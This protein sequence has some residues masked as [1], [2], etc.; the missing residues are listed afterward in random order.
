M[1]STA[2]IP[3]ITY[4][5]AEQT[6][7]VKRT[8]LKDR[9]ILLDIVPEYRAQVAY[10][11]RAQVEDLGNMELLEQARN[12]K[13]EQKE[14]SKPVLEQIV[15]GKNEFAI[16]I[17]KLAALERAVTEQQPPA[18]SPVIES[19]PSPSHSFMDSIES[20]VKLAE[21]QWI[22]TRKELRSLGVPNSSIVPGVTYRGFSFERSGNVGRSFG[23]RVLL[24]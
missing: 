20:L 9:M 5:E 7:G 21:N 6:L 3:E 23:W 12:T 14:I 11:T 1:L 18:L 10:L 8:A 16:M 4:K 15:M 2:T 19:T 22:V 13:R 17:E 24:R